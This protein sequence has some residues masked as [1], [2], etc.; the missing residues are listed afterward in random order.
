MRVV[1]WKNCHMAT[2]GRPVWRCL[3]KLTPDVALLREVSGSLRRSV[4]AVQAVPNI[5]RQI[6]AGSNGF[7]HSSR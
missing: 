6:V 5:R 2:A 3:L 7:R 4:T 1:T